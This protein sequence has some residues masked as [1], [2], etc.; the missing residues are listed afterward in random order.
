M[1]INI[2][3]STGE[4]AP[5]GLLFD[6]DENVLI[7][8]TVGR[9][10]SGAILVSYDGQ[11]ADLQESITI[12][13]N[14]VVC[15]GEKVA[16]KDALTTKFRFDVGQ[17]QK[18]IK[19]DASQ[20]TSFFS[21]SN[22]N[23][24][25][26]S[27]SLTKDIKGTALAENIKKTI[28][29]DTTTGEL[30][31]LNNNNKAKD[32]KFFIQ[33]KSS[34]GALIYK[35]FKLIVTDNKPPYL[36]G[37]K[38]KKNLKKVTIEVDPTD[39]NAERYIKIKLPVALDEEK[40]VIKY[41]FSGQKEKWISKINKNLIKI[42]TQKIKA[43]DAGTWRIGIRL[44]DD[45]YGKTRLETNY[46][47]PIEIKYKEPVVVVEE[48]NTTAS[49]ANSTLPTGPIGS[50]DSADSATD[51]ATA[52]GDST[53]ADATTDNSTA[54]ADSNDTTAA[55]AAD[56]TKDD[57]T[58]T[59]KSADKSTAAAA[60][61]TTDK[62]TAEE[63]VKEKVVK[64]GGQLAGLAIKVNKDGSDKEEEKEPEKPAPP[65]VES[66]PITAQV[67]LQATPAAKPKETIAPLVNP[68]STAIPEKEAIKAIANIGAGLKKFKKKKNKKSKN[69]KDKNTTG[70]AA[71]DTTDEPVEEEEEAPA[72][73]LGP[74]KVK[75][76]T[77]DASGGLPI[78]PNQPT[79]PLG[80]TSSTDPTTGRRRLFI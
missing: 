30:T 1:N 39:K 17:D 3:S 20:M 68:E 21:N 57:S 32:I 79:V 63:K 19:I 61:S 28:T 41:K 78:K 16:V 2:V 64:S 25:I 27:F 8:T 67:T 47:V 10:F 58:A 59:A 74:M 66:L 49:A 55:T 73:D 22:P 34:G 18:D 23:C 29:F 14:F 77:M 9:D 26:S 7:D 72:E 42:D 56:D 5:D 76:G 71:A 33:A 62:Q 36:K 31:V 60:D 12:P 15:G 45:K 37:F 48:K 40:N 52:A 38:G 4:D 46:I 65:P 50:A 6:E 51:N 70:T 24:A 11:C 75:T 13:I 53:A 69:K 35:K 43:L 54:A 80:I 44:R